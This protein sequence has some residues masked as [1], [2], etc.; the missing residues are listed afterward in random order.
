VEVI[1]VSDWLIEQPADLRIQFGRIKIPCQNGKQLGS[2]YVGPESLDHSLDYL[3]RGLLQKVV[4]VE[5][6]VILGDLAFELC[7]DQ[8]GI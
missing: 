2:D 6:E 5:F 8:F 7:R 3:P 4:N 1:E